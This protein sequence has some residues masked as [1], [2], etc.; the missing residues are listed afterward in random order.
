[1]LL[2]KSYSP[3]DVVTF[4]CISGEELIARYQGETMTE[5]Q[6]SKPAT[7]SPS[8]NG[9]IGLIPSMFSMDMTITSVN[10]LKSAVAMTAITNK[11][12]ADK[13]IQGTSGIKPASSL[14]GLVNA[15]NG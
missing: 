7:L 8:P 9:S 14:D 12:L 3:G 13:Y 10:L 2:N 15:K 4:K 1:M 6:L 5:F 11:E